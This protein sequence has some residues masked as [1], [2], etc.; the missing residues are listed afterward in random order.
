MDPDLPTPFDRMP[1]VTMRVVVWR[2]WLY[3]SDGPIDCMRLNAESHAAF[4][5]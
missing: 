2:Q 3:E 5:L 1:D 4:G